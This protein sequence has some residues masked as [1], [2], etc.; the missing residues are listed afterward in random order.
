ME[1]AVGSIGAV[2]RALA[3]GAWLVFEESL[4]VV[5]DKSW[6]NNCVSAYHIREGRT[7]EGCFADRADVLNEGCEE[8]PL[9][10]HSGRGVS[11]RAEP[12]QL[13]RGKRGASSL[14]RSG[15]ASSGVT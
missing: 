5:G 13:H 4:Q 10:A 9:G 7:T 2:G 3:V 12:R 1:L 11:A 8:A 6:G 15:S 14:P